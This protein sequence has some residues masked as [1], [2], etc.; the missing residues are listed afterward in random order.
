MP[1]KLFLFV[2]SSR[3]SSIRIDSTRIEMTVKKPVNESIG[4]DLQKSKEFLSMMINEERKKL[5]DRKV[6]RRSCGMSKVFDAEVET[7]QES[8][9]SSEEIESPRSVSKLGQ[10]TPKKVFHVHS[11]ILRIR[12]EDLHIGEDIGEGLSAKDK[13]S[14]NHHHHQLASSHVDVVLF[15]RPILPASPLSGKT[16]H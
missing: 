5:S 12:E 2:P 16:V 6:D 4:S 11:Q 13:I 14:G 10:W 1:P 7:D 3:S 15:S 9:G 8:I